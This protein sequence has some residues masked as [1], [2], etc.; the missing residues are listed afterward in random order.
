MEMNS[1]YLSHK[2]HQETGVRFS[3]FLKKFRISK[4]RELL[5][6]SDRSVQDIGLEVGYWNSN[7]FIKVFR[8][9]IGITPR[10]Y[11]RLKNTV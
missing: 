11:R 1:S 3:V 4:A 8:S 5:I 6:N 9:L 10:E 2:Y 7:Y